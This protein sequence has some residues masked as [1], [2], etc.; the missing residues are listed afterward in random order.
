MLW[1]EVRQGTRLLGVSPPEI[2][3]DVRRNGFVVFRVYSPFNWSS[4][5]NPAEPIVLW[6]RTICDLFPLRPIAV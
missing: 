5:M 2:S 6:F 3:T 4:L 1:P